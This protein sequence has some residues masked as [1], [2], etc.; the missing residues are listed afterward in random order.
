MKSF[1]KIIF[2][3]LTVFIFIIAVIISIAGGILFYKTSNADLILKQGYTPVKIYDKD[4]QLISTDNCYY[5]YTSIQ[6]ISEHIIHA[7]VA[8]E[9]R[10][11]YKHHGFSTKRIFKALVNLSLIHI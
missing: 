4:N 11:F 10:D 5:S 3:I 6:D 2:R 8:I 1:F 9:D 7:F